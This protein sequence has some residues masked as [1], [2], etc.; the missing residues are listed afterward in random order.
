MPSSYKTEH[1]GLN[2]WIGTDKPKRSDWVA[3]NEKTDSAIK[4]LESTQC[5]HSSDTGMHVT[6]VEKNKWN[7]GQAFSVFQYQ[8][9]GAA[10]RSFSLGKAVKFAIVY[11]VGKPPAGVFPT[12][13]CYSGYL[14]PQGCTDGLMLTA[15]GFSVQHMKT[16]DPSGYALRLNQENIS[17]LCI[18]WS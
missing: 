7:A 1:L 9:D 6:A 14:S 8:G 15:N 13:Y 4:Q 3:D 5:S 17:Y 11:A 12:F 2:R 16:P 18:Y 10:A